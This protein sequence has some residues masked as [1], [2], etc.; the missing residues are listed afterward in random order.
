VA[1]KYPLLSAAWYFHKR[2]INEIADKGSSE[3]VVRA[4]TRKINSGLHGLTERTNLFNKYYNILK[5]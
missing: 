3:A 2:D 1:T 5:Q 4:V